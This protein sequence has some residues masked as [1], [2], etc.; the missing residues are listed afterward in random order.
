MG[1][2][3]AIIITPS[4]ETGL[5]VKL[6]RVL[7]LSKTVPP[8]LASYS[9]HGV[10]KDI[11]TLRSVFPD[12]EWSCV[13]FRGLVLADQV[14]E[15]VRS[16]VAKLP[17][18]SVVAL[19]FCGH[20]LFEGDPCHGTLVCSMSQKIESQ[21][22]TDILQD[23]GFRGTFIRVVS[24]CRA[25]GPESLKK[26]EHSARC[27]EP[28]VSPE[29]PLYRQV[30]VCG[31][32]P[33]DKMTGGSPLIQDVLGPVFASP[34]TYQS[35]SSQVSWHSSETVVKLEPRV[36]AGKWGEMAETEAELCTSDEEEDDCFSRTID[37]FYMK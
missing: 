26:S 12:P 24:A 28:G 7:E 36:L 25:N 1:S 31:G 20:V 11:E 5:E 29:F 2:K 3:T 17:A 13:H 15:T 19:V 14:L 32:G 6:Q 18:K 10:A 21:M 22:I 30:F 27:V 4:Y 8:R 23:T 9:K 16:I 35:L 34:V 37:S 33:F